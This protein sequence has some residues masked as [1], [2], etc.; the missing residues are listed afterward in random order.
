LLSFPMATF[1]TNG[2]LFANQSRGKGI[3]SLLGPL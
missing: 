2:I 1:Q 3:S